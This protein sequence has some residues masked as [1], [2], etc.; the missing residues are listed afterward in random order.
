MDKETEVYIKK[1]LAEIMPVLQKVAMG[2]L[3]QSI[4]V[5]DEKDPFAEHFFA[6]NIFIDDIR[7]LMLE[8]ER[9]NQELAGANKNLE[10]E[11][12]RKTAGLREKI[13]ELEKFNAI[14]VN[15]E[16]KM[17]GLKEKVVNLENEI[18]K[19]EKK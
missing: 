19:L 1:R 6:L 15:R 10:E 3:N 18:K 11:V 4:E 2:D 14:A 9:K 5:K 8:N 13:E 12:A 17:I 16:L 7:D